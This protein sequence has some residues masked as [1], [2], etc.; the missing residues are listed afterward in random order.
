MPKSVEFEKK[1]PRDSKGKFRPKPQPKAAT[2]NTDLLN[3]LELD[4][5]KS[6]AS[7]AEN[8]NTRS[9]SGWSGPLNNRKRLTFAATSTELVAKSLLQKGEHGATV[10]CR[11][12]FHL[13]H[14]VLKDHE[15]RFGGSTWEGKQIRM[16]VAAFG[17]L[18]DLHANTKRLLKD[19]NVDVKPSESGWG[20][21]VQ[22][23]V[24]SVWQL[25]IREQSAEDLNLLRQLRMKILEMQSDFEPGYLKNHAVRSDGWKLVA[26][27]HLL[28]AAKHIA[29][30]IELRNMRENTALDV[31]D[32]P[33][34]HLVSATQAA[35]ETNDGDFMFLVGLL[36]V[37]G[38]ALIE[39]RS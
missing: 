9:S 28:S 32:N 2:V 13:L 37:V 34:R 5:I 36:D 35:S 7:E 22:E 21:A 29:D 20:V 3:L 39:R 26:S 25:L 19:V 17:F 11:Q 1:H 31:Q 30:H 38:S 33:K 27:Y 24:L 14:A 6:A 8:F 18:G 15:H 4:H 16:R 12:A 10:A 23:S